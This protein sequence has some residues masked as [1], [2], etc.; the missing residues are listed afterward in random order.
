MNKGIFIVT[1][2]RDPETRTIPSGK[3]VCTF[4][5][6][7]S[8]RRGGENVTLWIKVTAWDKLGENCQQYL[9]KGKKCCVVGPVSCSAYN[10]KDGKPHASLEVTAHEVEF[11]SPREDAA[12]P[13]QGTAAAPVQTDAQSGYVQ[14]ED[15]PEGTLPF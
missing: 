11:L 6:A 3:T 5:V 14:V 8:E 1:L 9:K 10:G 7:I 4:S 2:G 13:P 12:E 15:D